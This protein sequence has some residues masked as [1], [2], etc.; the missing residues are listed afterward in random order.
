MV[1]RNDVGAQKQAAAAA[2]VAEVQSGMLIGL[3]TGTTA[4]LAIAELAHR[5]G[6]GLVVRAVATSERTANAA[7]LAGITVIGFESIDAL[8]LAIDGVDEVD[9]TFVATKGGGG[10]MLR[11]KIVA[12][13]AH[14]MIAIADASKLVARLGARPIPLEVLPFASALVLRRAR[15][16]GCEPNLRRQAE[17]PFR[18]DQG[19]LVIDCHFPTIED[20]EQLAYA[21]ASI[22]GVLG[23]GLFLDEID[24]IYVGTP[25][26]LDRRDRPTAL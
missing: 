15:E 26:G 5:V 1:D 24:T 6:E 8:D 22:P 10:A 7:R 4:A 12:S 2:A 11:E 14:R 21:F 25:H 20:P 3:G 23:H 13:A 18:T 16:L 17:L 9:P 19:N